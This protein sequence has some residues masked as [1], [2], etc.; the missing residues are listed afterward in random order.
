[1]LM[2]Q[3]ARRNRPRNQKESAKVFRLLELV[4][5]AFYTKS[6]YLVG[7]LAFQVYHRSIIPLNTAVNDN[8]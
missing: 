5:H 4:V 8:S 2:L 7:L 3:L 6:M 1:M